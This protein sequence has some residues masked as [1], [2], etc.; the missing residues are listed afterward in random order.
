MFYAIC[1]TPFLHLS[2]VLPNL[3]HSLLLLILLFLFLFFPNQNT[4]TAISISQRDID[5]TY[6]IF[7][8]AEEDSSPNTTSDDTDTSQNFDI[9]SLAQPVLHRV[10]RQIRKPGKG[11]GAA[12]GE[13]SD[14][15][16]STD[17]QIYA[18]FLGYPWWHPYV[19]ANAMFALS[20]VIALLRMLPYVVVSNIVGPLQISLGSMVK[21]TAHFFLVVAV[22]LFSFAV[23]LC[24]IY[25]YYEYTKMLTC[26]ASNESC[27]SGYFSK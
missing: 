15:R 19:L 10:V 6:P 9:L 8:N 3:H 13:E 5:S 20:T 18:E 11:A 17:S 26:K 22:V 24:Y 2:C 25:S 14:E 16:Y 21:R 27:S 12:A 7:R 1:I 23:G 4:D